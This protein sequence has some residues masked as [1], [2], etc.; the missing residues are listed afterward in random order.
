MTAYGIV[1]SL[2]GASLARAWICTCIQCFRT[3][4]EAFFH[5]FPYRRLGEAIAQRWKLPF[6]KASTCSPVLV[7]P[8]RKRRE[9]PVDASTSESM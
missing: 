9:Q 4:A 5:A 7:P 6:K 1:A 2:C 8:S 3:R